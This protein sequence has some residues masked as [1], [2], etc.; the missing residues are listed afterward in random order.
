[1]I[2]FIVIEDEKKIQEQIKK[3]LRKIAFA[4]DT[5]LDVMYFSKY[6]KELEKVIANDAFRKVYILDIE[7]EG[8]IS[9][10][11][12]AHKI[13]EKDWDSEIIFVTCHDKMF[14]TVYRNILDVFDF[15]E[16]FHDMEN[17]LEKDLQTIYSQKFDKKMLKVNGRNVDLEIYLKNILYITRDKEDR[18]LI[19]Y[20]NNIEFKII[21]TLNDILKKLDSRFI[22]THRCCL[23][24]TEHIMEY[25][26]RK[27]YFVLDNGTKVEL[28]SKKYRK[29]RTES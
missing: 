17:R 15:I 24:N 6:N 13:R 18:K 12:I 1:M 26:Y 28:L 4:N 23:A 20:T 22:R 8:S 19:I 14:E 5:D 9:G 27:G 25:N 3:V 10:I 2:Q 11:D 21:S 16:K 29:K 7:L